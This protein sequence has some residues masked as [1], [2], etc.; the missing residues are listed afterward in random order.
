MTEIMTGLRYLMNVKGQKNK[1]IA[2]ILDIST[3]AVSLWTKK[4]LFPRNI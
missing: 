3:Q 1:D 4:A 2:K